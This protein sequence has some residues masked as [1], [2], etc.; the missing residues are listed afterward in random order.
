MIRSFDEFFFLARL[1]L[2]LIVLVFLIYVLELIRLFLW[3]MIIP[4]SFMIT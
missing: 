2:S 1:V 4:L 3:M